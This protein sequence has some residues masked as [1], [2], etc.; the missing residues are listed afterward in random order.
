VSSRGRFIEGAA[1]PGP[2]RAAFGRVEQAD[3][4]LLSAWTAAAAGTPGNDTGSSR[5]RAVQ[6]SLR[7]D[8]ALPSSWPDDDTLAFH[9]CWGPL[10]QV[11]A[12]RESLLRW[13]ADD[14]SLEPRDIRILTPDLETYAPLIDAVF[15]RRSGPGTPTDQAQ[16]PAIPV[17]IANLG[18]SRT[19]PVADAL[20]RIL[21]LAEERVTAVRLFELLAT[22]P[23]K[24]RFGLSDTDVDDLRTLVVD[25]KLRWGLDAADRSS[26]GQP[27]LFQNTVEFGLQRMVLGVLLPDEGLDQGALDSGG[28]NPVVP[29]EIEGRERARRVAALASLVQAI[30]LLR[31]ELKDAAGDAAWSAGAWRIR[32]DGLLEDLTATSSAAGWLRLEVDEALDE[33][34]PGVEGARLELAAVRR[35]LTGR[36]DVR[37]SGGRVVSGAVSVSRLAPHACLPCRVLALVGMDDASFPSASIP[38][39]WDPLRTPAADHDERAIQRQAL[40]DLLLAVEERVFVSWSGFEL[41]RGQELPPCVPVDELL[42][43]IA[44]A[45]GLP[46][47]GLVVTQPR[48]PW[49]PTALVD[50]G[51]DGQALAAGRKL[52]EV[53]GGTAAPLPGLSASRGIVLPKEEHP[54]R[55]LTFN[56][57]AAALR[58][59]SKEYL[60]R[61]MA[62]YMEESPDPIPNRE[63]I[64]LNSLNAWGLRDELLRLMREGDTASAAPEDLEARLR[65]RGELPLEAGG[66]Q[67]LAESFELVQEALESWREVDGTEVLPADD[68]VMKI[69]YDAPD[70]MLTGSPDRIRRNGDGQ[71][72]YEWLFAGKVEKGHRPLRVW[73]HLLGACAEAEEGAV[74]GAHLRGVA[75]KAVDGFLRAP[76]PDEAKKVLD[77]LAA[78]WRL[79]R[80]QALPLFEHTSQ[81]I[82]GAL[83]RHP[84]AAQDTLVDAIGDAWF[85]GDWGGGYDLQDRH[86]AALWGDYDPHRDPGLVARSAAPV[87]GLVDLAYRVWTQLLEHTLTPAKGL[88]KLTAWR[89]A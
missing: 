86:V 3:S 51:F 1:D 84:D 70:L 65:G 64:T 42:H 43:E 2:L 30:R 52:E 75:N 44:S 15:A 63:P 34:L 77:D 46:R 25:S 38:R 5:L 55:E 35:L 66:E 60:Q 56:Q 31:E 17:R 40:Q 58:R 18:L 22:D 74:L 50:V 45:A 73:V 9:R 28:G 61:R 79:S 41:G 53:R 19:N 54:I 67:Q 59:P 12:L 8:A 26:V 27:Q 82:G 78:I 13:F 57:L 29:M 69:R 48:Q 83:K 33:A 80:R 37:R 47:H 88:A 81:K 36:F 71:L 62:L 32:I 16:G 39:A 20:L 76:P 23:I 72:L 24:R 21:E 4:E 87:D 68:P 10:R 11:E 89:D 6:A 7:R 14:P 49:S 85:G